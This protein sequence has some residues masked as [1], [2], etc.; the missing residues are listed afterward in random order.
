MN[1]NTNG[2]LVAVL[3][4]AGVAGCG[5]EVVGVGRPNG[6]L[7]TVG[8]LE[9]GANIQRAYVGVDNRV[10]VGAIPVVTPF[11]LVGG[12]QVQL[13]VVTPDSSP[14]RFEVWQA[15]VDEQATLLMPVD[16]PSGF[17]LENVD[18]TEDGSW[19][20][21]FP[22]LPVGQV[23]VHMDC[24]GGEH[25]CSPARQPGESCPAGWSC[26]EGLACQ[27]PVGACGALA[28]AGTCVVPPTACAANAAP[29]CGC[30]GTTYP[31]ECAARLGG[32]AILADGPCQG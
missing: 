6:Q 9:Q 1:R 30:N 3:A 14:V 23:I 12:A 8:Q 31:S 21:V 24:V 29:V 16:A 10:P 13:E 5:G 26:D 18:A 32:E 2:L 7:S 17:A 19:M 22:A 20:I 28:A 4:L 25:G 27:L 15:H 11:D